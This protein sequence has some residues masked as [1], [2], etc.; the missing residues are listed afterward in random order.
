MK[1][2]DFIHDLRRTEIG[3]IIDGKHEPFDLA[4]KRQPWRPGQIRFPEAT[5]P[6]GYVTHFAIFHEGRI[7]D[8]HKI[9]AKQKIYPGHEAC[10]TLTS[11]L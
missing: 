7:T 4:Y 1:W 5:E 8:I 3:I 6:W 10:I 9:D 11:G 2:E